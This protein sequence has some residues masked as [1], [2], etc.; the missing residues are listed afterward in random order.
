VHV[1]EDVNSLQTADFNF[2]TR[3]SVTEIPGHEHW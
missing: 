1:T 2:F 3:N